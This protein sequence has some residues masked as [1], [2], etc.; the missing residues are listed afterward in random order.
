MPTLDDF[1]ANFDR[2]V[3]AL[4]DRD[5]R[6]VKA[7]AGRDAS[8]FLEMLK[9]ELQKWAAQLA[10]GKLEMDDVEYMIGSRRERAELQELKRLGLSQA[11]RDKLVNGIVEL[12]TK[13]LSKLA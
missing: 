9:P 13:A 4:V 11:K 3:H 2:E 6:D 5:W 7:E 1:L 10:A 8:A 12:A